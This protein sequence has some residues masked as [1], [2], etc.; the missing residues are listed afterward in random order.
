MLASDAF[1]LFRNLIDNR[2]FPIVHD[3]GQ[4]MEG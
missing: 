1:H 2:P 3:I 4:M